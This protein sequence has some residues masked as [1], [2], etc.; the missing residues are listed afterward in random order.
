MTA[1]LTWWRNRSMP[2]SGL[3]ALPDAALVARQLTPGARFVVA[4]PADRAR[5]G[6]PRA[7][8]ALLAPAAHA[9]A[10]CAQLHVR[11]PRRCHRPL[12]PGRRARALRGL[13][14]RLRRADRLPARHATPRAHRGD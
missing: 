11:Q 8:A 12:D 9:T 10:A 2:R 1:P 7:P 3:G 13:W 6:V 4:S 14:V 5:R